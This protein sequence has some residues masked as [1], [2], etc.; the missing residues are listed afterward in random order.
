MSAKIQ[1]YMTHTII[2]NL[3]GPTEMIV[4]NSSN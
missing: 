2:V 4:E 3:T 1:Q